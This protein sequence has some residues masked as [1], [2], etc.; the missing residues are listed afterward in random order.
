EDGMRGFHVTGVQTCA[1]PISLNAG[2]ASFDVQQDAGRVLLDD[3]GTGSASPVDVAHLK[4][5]GQVRL[6]AGAQVASGGATTAVLDGEEGLL[7]VLPFEGAT[8]FDAEELEPTAEVEGAG[9][10]AVSQDGTVFVA[11]PS[12]GT[13]W[14]VETSSRGVADGEPTES[15]LPVGK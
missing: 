9:A 11:V 1:L 12:T 8:S 5:S 4:L 10:V 14:T 3:A 7:W 6:P 15:A 13:L 2:S